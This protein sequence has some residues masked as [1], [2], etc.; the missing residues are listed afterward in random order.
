[1]KT[2][3]I[4]LRHFSEV[5]AVWDTLIGIYAEV[6]ADRLHDP[7]YSVERYGER[8]ARHATEP[9]WEAVVGYEGEE[10]VGYIYAN[11]IE[12]DD[13][14]WKRINHPLS[15]AITQPSTLAIKELMV[16]VPWRK[17]G[18]SRRI[19]DSLL[20]HRAEEQVTLMVNPL[21]GDGK[22]HGL[23][24]SWG[25]KDIGQSQP[26][27]DSPVLMAMVRARRQAG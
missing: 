23:Y 8:L 9:G 2:A 18:A 19:H 12:H 11:R 3:G 25:Y 27:P 15:E 22:V 16:R 21:A 13:R 7:H 5:E 4:E 20:A 24:E 1:M 10:A 14:W 6:R 26:S 17:T